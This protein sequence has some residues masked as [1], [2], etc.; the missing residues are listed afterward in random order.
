M[1]FTISHRPAGAVLNGGIWLDNCNIFL[2]CPTGLTSGRTMRVGGPP[3]PAQLHHQAQDLLHKL[4]LSKFQIKFVMRHPNLFQVRCPWLCSA[5]LARGGTCSRAAIIALGNDG[6]STIHQLVNWHPPS[7]IHLERPP[8]HLSCGKRPP[9]PPPR[10]RVLFEAGD[11][12]A[13]GCV[14]HLSTRPVVGG[15]RSPVQRPA[16]NQPQHE[17]SLH[18]SALQR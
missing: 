11:L 8:V 18:Y 5:I 6:Y 9:A 7:L 14:L 15:P 12:P 2:C 1:A 16:W 3:P 4:H 13:I 17:V 10:G